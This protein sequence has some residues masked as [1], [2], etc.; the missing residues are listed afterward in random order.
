MGPAARP[1]WARAPRELARGC[2]GNRGTP[3]HHPWG[4][5]VAQEL[6]HQVHGHPKS[7]PTKCMGTPRTHLLGAWTPQELAHE[8]HGTPR[9]HPPS[10]WAPQKPI[11]WVYGHPKSSPIGH[12]GTPRAHPLCVWCCT[13]TELTHHACRHPKSSPTGCTDTPGTRP[14]GVQLSQEPPTGYVGSAGTPRAHPSAARCCMGT[15]KA[16]PQDAWAPRDLAR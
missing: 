13:G 10:A 1:G 14:P 6:A 16:H 5:R 9:A 8:V 7:S 15:P 2:A 11:H 3:T 4:A 12:M